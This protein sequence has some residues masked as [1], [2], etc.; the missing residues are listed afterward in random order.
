MKS[1]LFLL[2][3][4]SLPLPAQ[5]Q[6]YKD[7]RTPLTR[8]GKPNLT[9]PAPRLNGKPDLSGVWQVERPTP[10]ELNHVLGAGVTT[11][12]IDYYDA[13]KYVFDIFWGLK[14]EEEP[15]QPAAKSILKTRSPTQTP[16]TQCLPWGVPGSMFLYDIKLIQSPREVVMLFEDGAPARQIYTDGR[17]LP[18][19]PEPTWMG[20]SVAKWQGD[21]LAVQTTGFTGNAWL[22]GPGHPRSESMLIRE[23]FH[24]RDF[25]HLDLEVTIEDPKYYTRPIDLKTTF[26]LI[27]DGDIFEFVCENEKDRAHVAQP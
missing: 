24:R 26:N 15:L 19:D 9:A 1:T 18:K 8:D 25:G 21:T 10:E 22:D 7:P 20:S 16:P 6:V 27:P 12:Q 23:N 14:P 11:S 4:F 5:W 3:V 13:G 17:A 2:A